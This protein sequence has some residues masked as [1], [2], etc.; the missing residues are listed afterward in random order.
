MKVY[1]MRHGETPLNK[2]KKVNA[3]IDETLSPEGIKQVEAAVSAIPKGIKH[4]YSSS[5]KRAKQTAEIIGTALQ[6]PVSFHHELFEIRMG[7]L[8]GKSW[9]EMDNGLELKK[10][11]RS[12]QFDY[13]A[14]GGESAHDVKKRLTVFLQGI[15]GLHKD[16]EVLL[17]THGGL[18]RVIQYLEYGETVYETVGN[19]SLS[20]FNLNKILAT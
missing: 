2:L 17:V 4:I 6:I 8:A 18:I 3:E 12:I 11:H 16:N 14:L 10:R 1:V 5:L 9:E 19:V 13:K 15:R 7:S 20:E